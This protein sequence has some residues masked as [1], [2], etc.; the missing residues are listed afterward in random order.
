MT[1]LIVSNDREA[2][3]ALTAALTRNGQKVHWATDLDDARRQI[4]EV[5]PLLVVADEET[6]ADFTE[7]VERL[8]PYSRLRLMCADR[9]RVEPRVIYKPFDA[10]ELAVLLERESELVRADRRRLRLQGELERA[11]RLATVGR[12]S[13]SM[14][15][16]INNPLAVISFGVDH[17]S[18]QQQVAGEPELLECLRDMGMAVGRIRGFVEHISGYVRRERPELEDASLGSAVDVALRLVRPRA[19]QRGVEVAVSGDVQADA[20]HDAARLSQ[21]LL[22]LLANAVDAAADGGRHVWLEIAPAEREVVLRVDDDGAGIAQEIAGRL[23]QAF[24]TTKP[25]GS[26]TGLGLA[27]THQIVTDHMGSVTVGPRPERGTRAEI[28]IPRFCPAMH[29]V[30]IVDHDAAVRRALASDLRREGFEVLQSASIEEARSLAPECSVVVSE[31]VLPDGLSAGFLEDLAAQNFRI[32]RIV[33][34][35]SPSEALPCADQSFGKPWERPAL[36]RAVRRLAL[37]HQLPSTRPGL[38]PSDLSGLG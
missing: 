11:E 9:S 5:P 22:N 31:V 33:V 29:R 14:V 2:A 38:A 28:R 25:A 30:L 1:V 16:E 17:L 3:A 35:T 20:V 32:G 21:A 6:D 12:L 8:S 34:T 15:H 27:I 23:F 26:G 10:E 19:R 36:V 7:S 13:A 24:A 18:E 37:V 4:D